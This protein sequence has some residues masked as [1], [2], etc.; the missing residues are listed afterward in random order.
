MAAPLAGAY[1]SGMVAFDMLK[2]SRRLRDAGFGE[3][4]AEALVDGYNQR[5]EMALTFTRKILAPKRPA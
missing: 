3:Q 4:K 2:A 1:D 5:D